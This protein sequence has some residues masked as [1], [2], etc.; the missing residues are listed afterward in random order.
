MFQQKDKSI[1]NFCSKEKLKLGS[2]KRL[3]FECHEFITKKTCDKYVGMEWFP[4]TCEKFVDKTPEMVKKVMEERKQY[5][6]DLN[7]TLPS[8]IE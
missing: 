1:K 3:N 8:E 7:K 5:L 4:Y 6:A 2:C